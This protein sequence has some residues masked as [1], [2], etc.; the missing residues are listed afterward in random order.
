MQEDCEFKTSLGYIV[1][2]Y[3]KKAKV[4]FKKTN[5]WVLV[6]H[7]YNPSYSRDRDREDLGFNPA[8]ANSFERTY[9]E[10][11]LHKKGLVEMAQDIEPESKPQYLP[12]QKSAELEAW[13][14]P[15]SSCLAGVKP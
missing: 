13:F 12:L 2:P 6:A 10:N 5:S 8:R 1:R 7:A 9:L 3:L 11:T 14:K 4:F 15:L